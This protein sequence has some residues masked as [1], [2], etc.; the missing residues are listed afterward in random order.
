MKKTQTRRVCFK[1][2]IR[3]KTSK[4]MDDIC[5]LIPIDDLFKKTNNIH[6]ISIVTCY[7]WLI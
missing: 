4:K 2:K 6:W 3:R 5:A 7:I 1:N